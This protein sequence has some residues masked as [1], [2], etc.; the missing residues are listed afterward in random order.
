MSGLLSHRI[1][2]LLLNA[3]ASFPS[4]ARDAKEMINEWR[5]EQRPKFRVVRSDADDPAVSADRVSDGRADDPRVE[6][7]E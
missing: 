1:N 3:N 2:Q 4:Q 7:D 5:H 6:Q